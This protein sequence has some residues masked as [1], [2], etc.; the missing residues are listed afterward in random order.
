[1]KMEY[2]K[3]MNLLDATSDSASRFIN[4]KCIEVYDQSGNAE[5]RYKPSKQ[6]RFKAS[7]PQSDLCD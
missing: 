4:K 6:I 2:V 7:M 3:I 1:M 5:N